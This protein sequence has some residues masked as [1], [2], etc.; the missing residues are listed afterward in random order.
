[1]SKL[2]LVEFLTEKDLIKIRDD[3]GLLQATNKAAEIELKRREYI[4]D[5]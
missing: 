3:K 5:N 2:A 1:M 4:K